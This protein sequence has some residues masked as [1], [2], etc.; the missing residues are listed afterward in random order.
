MPIEFVT[1]I[2]PGTLGSLPGLTGFVFGAPASAFSAFTGEIVG[3]DGTATSAG[4]VS[5]PPHPAIPTN[6]TASRTRITSPQARTRTTCPLYLRTDFGRQRSRNSGSLPTPAAQPNYPTDTLIRTGTEQGGTSAGLRL[7]RG[8][9]TAVGRRDDGY[10]E[11]LQLG[12]D[13]FRLATPASVI[14]VP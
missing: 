1:S 12:N 7:S 6:S 4:E 3:E 5:S 14:L 2:P 8:R 10:L 9:A 11:M 13:F